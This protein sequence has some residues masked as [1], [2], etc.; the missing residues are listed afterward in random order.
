MRSLLMRPRHVR[1]FLRTSEPICGAFFSA[2]R[3]RK[4]THTDTEWE[5]RH[6]V[7]D[8]QEHSRLEISNAMRR[9]N[10]SLPKSFHPLT[11]GL[12]HTRLPRKEN[13]KTTDTE[14]GPALNSAL[15]K[16]IVPLRAPPEPEA[17]S[18]SAGVPRSTPPVR[19][20]SR[21]VCPYSEPRPFQLLCQAVSTNV[22][23]T[24]CIF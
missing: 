9:A 14:R 6:G 17:A 22:R 10:P 4:Q 19:R 11:N 23:R 7:Q 5:Q 21:I 2:Q 15:A 16:S 24:G 1:E 18:T 3:I 12:R 20:Q 13:T 8:G